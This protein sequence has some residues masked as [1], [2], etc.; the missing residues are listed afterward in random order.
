MPVRVKGS[1]RAS[2]PILHVI[3]LHFGMPRFH[4]A[5]GPLD[6]AQAEHALGQVEETCDHAIH[7]EVRS[8]DLLIEIIAGATEFFG[9]ERD[10]G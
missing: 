3:V 4:F 5:D 8:K 2:L 10:R 9:P 1:D 7:R 6:D